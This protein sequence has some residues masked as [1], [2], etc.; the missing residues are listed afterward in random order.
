MTKDEAIR[1]IKIV[2]AVAEDFEITV[3]GEE[4][5]E[6]KCKEA[7]EMATKALKQD[8][9]EDEVSRLSLINKLEILMDMYGNDFYWV[10]RKIIDA[11]PSVQPK[12]RMGRWIEDN[13]EIYSPNH[14][15]W[16]CSECGN[17]F[18][19]WESKP[20]ENNFNYCPNCGAKMQEVEE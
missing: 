17:P 16:V 6:E 13:D 20:K 10:V 11:E 9:C 8:P 18:I 2:L 1:I 19:L 14:D 7:V 12:Q 5:T 3:Q 15:V 4:F